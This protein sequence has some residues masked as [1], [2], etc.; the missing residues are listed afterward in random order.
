[1]STVVAVVV[2]TTIP[3]LAMAVTT[4]IFVGEQ[5]ELWVD[6]IV[7]RTWLCIVDHNMAHATSGPVG[8][9]VDHNSEEAIEHVF[10]GSSP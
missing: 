9:V 4:N 1:V 5:Q 10:V 2:Q 6:V 8:G 3:R 7:V